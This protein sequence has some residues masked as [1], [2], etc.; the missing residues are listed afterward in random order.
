MCKWQER[1]PDLC[2]ELWPMH[3]SHLYTSW[4]TLE[5]W[6]FSWYLLLQCLFIKLQTNGTN[7]G[8]IGDIRE[9]FRIY[10]QCTQTASV[11]LSSFRSNEKKKCYCLIN[12]EE[13]AKAKLKDFIQ[14]WMTFRRVELKRGS[15]LRLLA[16]LR[17]FNSVS[18]FLKIGRI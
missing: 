5:W 8:K 16:N 1:A 6:P 11:L 3:S 15:L 12:C 10:K 17:A 4:G 2:A 13:I 7:H 9:A 14:S 18:N